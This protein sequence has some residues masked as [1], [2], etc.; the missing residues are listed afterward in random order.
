MRNYLSI[1]IVIAATI[2]LTH[3]G[4][5]VFVPSPPACYNTACPAHCAFTISGYQLLAGCT[6]PSGAF[7]GN[8]C[9]ACDERVFILNG[10]NCVPHLLN[11]EHYQYYQTFG[12]AKI[13]W[14]AANRNTEWYDPRFVAPL[15]TI[16]RAHY[17]VRIKFGIK[18]YYY[19]YDSYYYPLNYSMDGTT[20]RYDQAGQNYWSCHDIVTSPLQSHYDVSL[21]VGWALTNTSLPYNIYNCGN[22]TCGGCVGGCCNANWYGADC[23][24][25]KYI[26]I[27]DLLVM[28]S[29]CP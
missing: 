17:A 18:L 1:L 28:V 10:T 23:C 15:I 19:D 14:Y 22:C 12:A 29:R 6:S 8:V 9:T 13:G 26:Q 11:N 5:T 25:D 24:A 20:Y 16:N 21:T 4:G 7:M 27:F 2:Y 3:S